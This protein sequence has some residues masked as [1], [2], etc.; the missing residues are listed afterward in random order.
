MK[1]CPSYFRRHVEMPECRHQ[2]DREPPLQ[3]LLVGEK[4]IGVVVL[5]AL[6]VFELTRFFSDVEEQAPYMGI[7]VYRKLFVSKI[8]ENVL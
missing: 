2:H 1:R 4:V 8:R 6:F 7:D 3:I 5:S